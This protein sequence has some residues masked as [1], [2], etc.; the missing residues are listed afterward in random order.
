MISR[1]GALDLAGPPPLDLADPEHQGHESGGQAGDEEPAARR[2][3]PAG[4]SRGRVNRV[5]IVSSSSSRRRRRRRR[6]SRRVQA[7][8]VLLLLLLCYYYY[9]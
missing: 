8:L 4:S 7:V 3:H 5:G 2:R 6:R 1:S 9:Y